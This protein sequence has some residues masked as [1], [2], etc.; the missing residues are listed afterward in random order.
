MTRL[1][2]VLLVS[3][4]VIGSPA[5]RATESATASRE[6][7]AYAQAKPLLERHCLMCHSAKPSMTVYQTAPAGVVLETPEQLRRLAPR[8]LVVVSVTEQMPPM[9]M[10]GMNAAERTQI[11][12][13]IR[14]YGLLDRSAPPNPEEA[15]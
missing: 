14:E 9:N 8:I 4:A 12:E 10:T 1:C 15:P 13:L 7:A 6:A 5:A 11:A 3:I 2:L